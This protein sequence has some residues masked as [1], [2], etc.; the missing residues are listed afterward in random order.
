MHQGASSEI[1]K[2][3]CGIGGSQ[4]VTRH[5]IKTF[6]LLSSIA[7][8]SKGQEGHLVQLGNSKVQVQVQCVVYSGQCAVASLSQAKILHLK[9]GINSGKSKLSGKIYPREV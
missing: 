2:T 9:S 5:G 1:L 8:K 3:N 6:Q 4:K 7:L